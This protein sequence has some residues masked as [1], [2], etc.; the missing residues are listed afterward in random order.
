MCETYDLGLIS[1]IISLQMIDNIQSGNTFLV[2]DPSFLEAFGS[3]IAEHDGND[4]KR[5][6]VILMFE[7]PRLVSYPC[8]VRFHCRH[9]VGIGFV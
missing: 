3:F 9:I 2:P 8:L 7:V 1:S 4:R 5:F 6:Q